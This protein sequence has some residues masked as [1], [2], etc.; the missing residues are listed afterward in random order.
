MKFYAEVIVMLKPDLLDPQ[1]KAIEKSMRYLGL[2]S[3]QNT[4]VGKVIRFSIEKDTR[5]KAL[6]DVKRIARIL[7]SNPVIEDTEIEIKEEGE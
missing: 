1:G 3:V 4:R 2:E 7:L 5:E 6:E